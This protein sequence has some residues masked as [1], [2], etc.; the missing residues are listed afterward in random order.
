MLISHKYAEIDLYLN[1]HSPCKRYPRERAKL[2]AI[3]RTIHRTNASP[4]LIA[5]R[6]RR[7]PFN[8]PR[9]VV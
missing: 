1:T 8:A 4:K 3:S 6:P 5:T 7:I 9:F 2:A